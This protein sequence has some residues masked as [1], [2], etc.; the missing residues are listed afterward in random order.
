MSYARRQ[1]GERIQ[2]LALDRFLRCA[3]ALGNVAHDDGVAD[4]LAVAAVVG[5][6][7]F[8]S[9]HPRLDHQRHDVK[10]DE[11]VSR[12]KN[13]EVAGNGT[14]AV[15]ERVPIEATHSF[16]EL[17]A[18]GTFAIEAEKLAGGVIEVSDS[19]R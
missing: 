5:R 6:G 11:P 7:I 9:V 12:I 1:Q 8:I 14:T 18:N 4:L 15:G 16:V 17:F 10:V 2:S 3:P 19:P 13:L